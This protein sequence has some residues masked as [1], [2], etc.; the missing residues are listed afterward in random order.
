[1]IEIVRADAEY[2]EFVE[3]V[4]HLDAELAT[5][6]GDEQTFYEQF[7]KLDQIKH[8]IV[9]FDD[10]KPV[11]CGALKHFD[12]GRAEVKRMYTLP[13]SRNKGI[14]EFVLYHLELWA[15]K[16]GYKSL[17][18]ETG[19]KQPFA[20]RLYEKSGYKRIPNYGQYAHVDNSI[21][22]EKKLER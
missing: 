22:F 18:L 12:D 2:A 6:Y 10:G 20:V 8:A 15:K 14:G 16:L 17:V 11:A 4:K 21:C 1:M 3:L 7:N 5:Y 9:A 13:K 19:N